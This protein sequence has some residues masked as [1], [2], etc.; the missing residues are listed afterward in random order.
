M[1]QRKK[2]KKKKPYILKIYIILYF[3]KGKFE[4]ELLQLKE[5]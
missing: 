4:K 5:I 3:S 1:K 2:K